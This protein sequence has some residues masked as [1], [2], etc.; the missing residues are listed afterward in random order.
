[1]YLKKTMPFILLSCLSTASLA[2]GDLAHNDVAEGAAAQI[3]DSQGALKT[4]LATYQN[5]YLVGS[6]Y[7]DTGYLPGFNFGEDSHWPYFVT[8]FAD[9]IKTTCTN[10]SVDQKVHCDQ[11]TAFLL[12][13]T[14][15]VKS[16]IVS[17]W[18]YYNFVALHDFGSSSQDAWNQA[19]S[20]MDPA[21]D[22]YVIVRKGIYDHPLV[23]WV[24]VNDLVTVYATMLK[25]NVI[26]DTVTAD[27]II[28]ANAVYYV[29]LGLTEDL[30]AYPAYTYDA[31]YHIPWGIANLENPDPQYGAFPE[32]IRQSANYIQ[33]TWGYIQ[34][35]PTKL[36]SIQSKK[37]DAN[38]VTQQA[39]ALV[40]KAM[41]D[42]LIQ[43]TPEKDAYGDVTFT[44]SSVQFTSEA[45]HQEFN[46][47]LT[48]LKSTLT[49]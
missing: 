30:I 23:W 49:Q 18:T 13:V 20:A 7:P 10:P 29:A 31:I 34:G 37:M 47:R 22:F 43:V 14:T 6:D 36:W 48:V 45:A 39:G 3:P 11:M 15:H 41:D 17:H 26:K 8:P 27:E 9:Y 4:L 35:N 46:N 1:M 42:H 28:K 40:K 16:D 5:E 25:N 12:G 44:P 38:I 32:M 33:D 2:L 19:H 21:S 24:P